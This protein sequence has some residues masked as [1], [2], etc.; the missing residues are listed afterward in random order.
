MKEKIKK[1]FK[2]ESG[3]TL[4]ELLVVI[5]IIAILA[6]IGAVNFS[7]ARAQARDAKRVA[8]L[9]QISSSIEVQAAATADGLYVA[10]ASLPADTIALEPPQTDDSYCYYVK[11][12]KKEFYITATGIEVSARGNPAGEPSAGNTSAN[13]DAVYQIGGTTACATIAA[14]VPACGDATILCMRGTSSF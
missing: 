3:F 13:W 4:I 8:D 6:T 5:G 9:S 2:S 11:T 14:A 7:G 1:F 12:D 10:G